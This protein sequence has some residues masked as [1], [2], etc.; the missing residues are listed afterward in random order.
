MRTRQRI[1]GHILYHCLKFHSEE[2]KAELKES[3]DTNR[4]WIILTAESFLSFSSFRSLTK[5]TK[6]L[7]SA[8]QQSSEATD[9]SGYVWNKLWKSIRKSYF[10]SFF[11]SS[12][13]IWI[14]IVT[15]LS[16]W[17]VPPY[18]TGDISQVTRAAG[19][20]TSAISECSW[21]LSA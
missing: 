3:Q 7:P 8:K 21:G 18:N 2:V 9:S 12:L 16:S 1:R 19:L 20:T 17:R 10:H 15:N 6:Q 4:I 13:K 5:L 14:Y 11:W